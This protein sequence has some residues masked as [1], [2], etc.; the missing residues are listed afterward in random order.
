MPLCM[1]CEQITPWTLKPVRFD[2]ATLLD[3]EKC[4]SH[5]QSFSLLKKS[6]IECELCTLMRD[7]ILDSRLNLEGN[8]PLREDAPVLLG[9]VINI[10]ADHR[11]EAPQLYNILVQCGDLYVILHAF[12]DPES[13]AARSNAVAGRLPFE[14]G[15]QAQLDVITTWLRNCERTHPN[16]RIG[17]VEEALADIGQDE[18]VRLPRRV[19]DIGDSTDPRIRLIDSSNIEGQYVALSHRWPVDPS[20]HFKTTKSSIHSRRQQIIFEDLP[21]TFQD[22]VTMTRSL[23]L[24]FLWIDSLCIIQDDSNDWD[25][26]S[27][28]MGK[29][30][31]ESTITIMAATSINSPNYEPAPEGFLHKQPSLNLPTIEMDYYSR[32][33]RRDGN[34]FIRY[35]DWTRHHSH[36]L[37]LLTRGWV[38]Q[39]HML[40]RR[41]VIYAPDQ[42][43]WKCKSMQVLEVNRDI[44]TDS[45][46]MQTTEDWEDTLFVDHWLSIAEIFSTKDLTFE[47]D[48]LPAISGLASY[49]CRRHGQE[50]F[51]G[52]LSGS[53]AEGLLWRPYSPGSLSRPTEYTA[54]TWSWTSLKGRIKM[55]AP[56][57]P[58]RGSLGLKCAIEDIK[59]ELLPEGK[60]PY[61]RLKD[62]RMKVTGLV[63]KAEMCREN[64]NANLLMRLRVGTRSLASFHLDLAEFAP[65]PLSIEEVACLYVLEHEES[66]LVLRKTRNL[67]E[68]E[69]IGI[70]PVDPAWFHDGGATKERITIV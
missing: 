19:V 16:C 45:Q 48:K 20:K 67:T 31:N 23:G 47:S 38:L 61:G 2:G 26:Q 33:W 14:T 37:D 1:L 32:D 63:I 10:Y 65:A 53:I 11:V 55:I 43:L 21:R 64:D 4:S 22:A 46:S 3:P 41:K 56:S 40:S 15:S 34:W 62:G 27:M 57:Q 70:A 8:R 52:L 58:S 17:G 39:E 30:Y 60:N 51:A 9:S 49:F 66:V 28:V 7:A 68:Y 5:H 44:K 54:P 69:R 24:R 13:Q 6:A 25:E 29:I 42:I 12:A 59:F 50:Y 35:M 18:S 36:N